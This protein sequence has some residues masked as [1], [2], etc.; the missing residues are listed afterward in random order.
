LRK[1]DISAA[2]GFPHYCAFFNLMHSDAAVPA[3][4]RNIQRLRR[5]ADITHFEPDEIFLDGPL[6]PQPNQ[7][8]QRT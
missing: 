7:K 5:V 4:E 2:A 1:T 6:N 8:G 3:T